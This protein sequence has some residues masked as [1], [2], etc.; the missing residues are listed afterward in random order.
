MIGP[1]GIERLRRALAAAEFEREIRIVAPVLIKLGSNFSGLGEI[2]G[3]LAEKLAFVAHHVFAET[4]AIHA[5]RVVMVEHALDSFGRQAGWNALHRQ[6]KA[7]HAISVKAAAQQ[8][9]VVRDLFSIY[10]AGV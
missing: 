5:I 1:F 6:A 10:L 7:H 8:H 3:G 2:A 9:L 4:L